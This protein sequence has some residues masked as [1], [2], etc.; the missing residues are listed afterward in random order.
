LTLITQL[1]LA[2]IVHTSM[3]I[4]LYFFRFCIFLYFL[5]FFQSVP[6]IVMAKLFT[7]FYGPEKAFTADHTRALC[8]RPSIATCLQSLRRPRTAR[9]RFLCAGLVAIVGVAGTVRTPSAD[10]TVFA[11]LPLGLNARNSSKRESFSCRQTQSTVQ[12]SL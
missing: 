10:V 2:I 8:G 7:S 4:F 6:P 3:Q 11:L 9:E 12:V 1:T 5:F